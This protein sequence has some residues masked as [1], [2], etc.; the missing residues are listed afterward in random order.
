MLQFAKKI[1]GL[2]V[3]TSLLTSCWSKDDDLGHDK[4]TQMLFRLTEGSLTEPPAGSINVAPSAF[5]PKNQDSTLVCHYASDVYANFLPIYNYGK[6][7]LKKDV[8]Y[9]LDIALFDSDNKHLN[10][11]FFKPDQIE[12]HQFFFN[13]LSNGSVVPNGISYYYSDVQ[14]KEL[15]QSPVGFSGFIRVN[16]DEE[17]MEL[18]LILVHLEKGDK[19]EANGKPNPFDKPSPRV[20]EFGDL[21]SVIPFTWAEEDEND[22]PSL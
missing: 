18:R 22:A 14:N 10:H 9:K 1:L 13:L 19:Y 15:V 7:K 12:K 20:L 17:D 5:T 6:I 4:P 2:I 11:Q 3:L 21:K 8:W 16:K